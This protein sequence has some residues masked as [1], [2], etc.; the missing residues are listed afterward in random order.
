MAHHGTGCNSSR[1]R[2]NRPKRFA[3][4]D[5]LIT[6][7]VLGLVLA[8]GGSGDPDSATSAPGLDGANKLPEEVLRG[9]PRY[10]PEFVTNPQS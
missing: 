7:V 8:C 2:N 9:A 6:G 5:R 4:R 10:G 3:M 1:S